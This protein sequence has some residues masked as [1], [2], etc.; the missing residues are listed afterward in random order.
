MP[1]QPSAAA[2]LRVERIDARLA[3]AAEKLEALRRKLA[4]SGDVV[5]EAGRR[6]TIEVFGE[7]LSPV[8]VVER[9][10]G[11]VRARGVRAVLEYTHKLDGAELAAESLR[12]PPHELQAAH[13]AAAPE[14]L[15]TLRRLR[16][17]IHTFQSA[18]LHHDVEVATAG[19]GT[20]RQ[21]Y[22][23]LDRVGVCVPG[24]AAAYPSTVLMTVVPAQAAGVKEIAVV[25]PPTKFGSYNQDLLATCH[26]LGV[27]EVY[28]MGG[29][30]A[31]AAL[32]YGLQGLTPRVD[33][34]VGPGNLFVA[35]AKRHVYG[36]VDIDSIAGPSE[37][38]VVADAT[39]P[40]SYAAADLIAQ[41][42]HAPGSSV[43]I[44]WHEPL[45]EQVAQQLAA[46]LA[47]SP[48]GDLARQS[49]E[50]F[51]AL[52]TAR[53]REHAAAIAEL[54]ATEH[55]HLACEDP[56]EM[57]G[58]IRSA[59]AVFLGPYSPVPVGDYAAGPSHVLPTGATAR[60][61]SGLSSNDFLR[62]NSVIHWSE[63]DLRQNAADIVR[64][65]EKE[66]LAAHAAAVTLRLAP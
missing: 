13:A 34:I 39:T 32:A 21:R 4:P 26:E 46:Q 9:I 37:V 6:K 20:L 27:T 35:L 61:A 55:L 11:D 12:V 1:N 56:Q 63:A 54:L 7:P 16:A 50:S 66:G 45:V 48:R 42:E 28:R 19:G 24:G 44:T 31:V 14:F 2:A 51:G 43:L 64:I 30:Q 49:L 52:V 57:L 53:D 5:S 36:E 18:I 15:D 25:A 60:F 23:P 3:G 59:G 33:K 22:L 62:S 58:R 47:L 29:A 65:A 40:A 10:C 8:Q 41:A 17:N 38:I